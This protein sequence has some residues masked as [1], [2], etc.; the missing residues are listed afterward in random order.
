MVKLSKCYY[1]MLLSSTSKLFGYFQ[2]KKSVNST[3][4]RFPS[5]MNQ[6]EKKNRKSE[7]KLMLI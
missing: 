3:L 5:K 6:K 1:H 7:K 2:S 4:E